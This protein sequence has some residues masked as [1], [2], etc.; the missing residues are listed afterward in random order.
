[1]AST[2]AHRVS[3]GERINAN[4]PPG[5]LQRELASKRI[6][7]TRQ[8]RVLVQVIENA[9]RHLDADEILDR[10]QRIDPNITRVTV[11]RTLDLLKRHGLI[12]ELDLLHL[13]G[14]RHYYESHGPRDHIHVACLRCGK[15]REFESELYETLMKQI[16]K[17]CG[18]EITVTRT[19]VGGVCDECRR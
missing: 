13:R 19:E 12:D 1:M 17:D 6:R 11:Y 4:E 15:V 8:R 7:L 5:H 10:A 16:S 9:R 3:T 14:D 2:P 18:I